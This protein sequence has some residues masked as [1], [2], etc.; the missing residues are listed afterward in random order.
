MQKL[1]GFQTYAVKPIRRAIANH[2]YHQLKDLD[3]EQKRAAILAHIGVDQVQDS[4][5]NAEDEQDKDAEKTED[6]QDKDA[7]KTEDEKAEA[8]KAAF[9]ASL[10]SY[11]NRL[12]TEPIYLGE[13]EILAIYELLNIRVHL[14]NMNA[15]GRQQQYG[16]DSS[17]PL[18]RLAITGSHYYLLAT[19]DDLNGGNLKPIP[20]DVRANIDPRISAI[21]DIWN[22]KESKSIEEDECVMTAIDRKV[23]EFS[24][25]ASN[26]QRSP[27]VDQPPS[28][29]SL[30]AAPSNQSS[31]RPQR[32]S[33]EKNVSLKEADSESD[34]ELDE[35]VEPVANPREFRSNTNGCYLPTGRH[36]P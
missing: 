6:E 20:N 22:N 24:T 14:F 32:K 30:L 2:L 18:I 25:S 28:V 5:S 1:Y 33:T 21:F 8:E 34:L 26:Q 7:E 12:A 23:T 11:C 4:Q 27:V 15:K 17:V 3:D 13:H 9:R 19:A 16:Q 36:S 29:S 31:T 10:A 35:S